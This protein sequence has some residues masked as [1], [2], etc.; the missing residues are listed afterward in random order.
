MVLLFG[1]KG[2]LPPQTTP[3]LTRSSSQ[4]TKKKQNPRW[5]PAVFQ[6]DRVGGD[7]LTTHPLPSLLEVRPHLSHPYFFPPNNPSL[8][9]AH[10]LSGWLAFQP[11]L[12]QKRQKRQGYFPPLLS[13]PAQRRGVQA[14]RPTLF[15]NAKSK[16]SKKCSKAKFLDVARILLE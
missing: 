7:A 1:Y 15:K 8:P 5:T 9:P 10:P 12:Q 14:C 6:T 16:R 11:T 4:E 13:N 3:N 2:S